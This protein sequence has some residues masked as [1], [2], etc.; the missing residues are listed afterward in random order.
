MKFKNFIQVE[1]SI[2]TRS[3]QCVGQKQSMVLKSAF[4]GFFR[5]SKV[6]SYPSV[7][8]AEKFIGS[9]SYIRYNKDAFESLFIHESIDWII[10]RSAFDQSAHDL[11]QC[12]PQAWRVFL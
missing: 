10:H 7:I 5:R 1:K 11:K 8:N 6:F 4:L 2:T 12:F 9:G 3:P